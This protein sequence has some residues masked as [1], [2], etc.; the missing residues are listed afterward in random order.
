MQRQK[1]NTLIK[2]VSYPLRLGIEIKLCIIVGMDHKM[3]RIGNHR[4]EWPGTLD[5][6]C[7]CTCVY[8]SV[9]V[10]VRVG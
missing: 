7:V 4:L 9:G 8:A 2:L 5:A 3:I 6:L 10:F 1:I